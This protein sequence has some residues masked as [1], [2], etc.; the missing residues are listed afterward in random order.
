MKHKT[1][2][3]LSILLAFVMVAGLLF[4]STSAAEIYGE[5]LTEQSP[6]MNIENIKQNIHEMAYTSGGYTVKLLDMKNGSASV[7]PDKGE[8]GTLITVTAIPAKSF[9]VENMSYTRDD[10][11]DTLVIIPFENNKGTF[12]M[13]A[14]NVNVKV[15]FKRIEKVYKITVNGG[16]AIDFEKDTKVTEAVKGKK[17]YL[18]Q[19]TGILDKWEVVKGNATIDERGIFI[20]PDE[21]VEIRGIY[22]NPTFTIDTDTLPNGT[23]G[24]AY[25]AEI[26]VTSEANVYMNVEEGE[27]PPGLTFNKDTKTISGTPTKEGTYTFTIKASTI[28]VQPKEYTIVIGSRSSGEGGGGGT[29]SAS[30]AIT[31]EKSENGMLKLSK[32]DASSGEKITLTPQPKE[33]YETDKITVTDKDGKEITVSKNSDGTFSFTMPSSKVSVVPTFKKTEG[34]DPVKPEPTENIPLLVVTIDK[35]SYQLNGQAMTMDSAPFIDGNDRTMLPVRVI[36]NALGISNENI[37]WNKDTKTA[38]FTRED[39][40][41]V[42][43]TVNSNIIKIGDEEV[44]IDTVPVIR[45]DRIYLPMR[46]LFNAFNVPNE[47]ILWDAAARTVTVIKKD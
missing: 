3:L 9:E 32:T 45:N 11:T 4:V 7:N 37:S 44:E 2:K 31:T 19:H 40:V 38:S 29:R 14:A 36:A 41:V 39:G 13:P 16:V 27:L 42:S 18:L 30:Y 8:K 6:A 24:S 26:K 15:T 21:D 12:E 10:N 23:V 17:I 46:A 47:N 22:I 5:A 34:A 33:G 20:M 35:T 28:I 25:S 1:R 43:C